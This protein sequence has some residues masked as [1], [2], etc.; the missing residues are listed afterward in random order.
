MAIRSER[1]K[2][3]KKMALRHSETCNEAD[4]SNGSREIGVLDLS[5]SYFEISNCGLAVV[6]RR[7]EVKEMHGG[8]DQPAENR[9]NECETCDVERVCLPARTPIRR[10][11]R[12]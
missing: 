6:S 1:K 4:I 7:F 12:A 8:F 2:S 3:K 9:G 5:I 10:T 11:G